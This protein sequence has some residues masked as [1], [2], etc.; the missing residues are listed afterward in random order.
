[1]ETK[2]ETTLHKVRMDNADEPRTPSRSR[3]HRV[4][5]RGNLQAE[6]GGLKLHFSYRSQHNF[7]DLSTT[8]DLNNS[9]SSEDSPRGIIV[10]V[11]RSTKSIAIRSDQQ[12]PKYIPMRDPTVVEVPRLLLNDRYPEEWE[13]AQ[14]ALVKCVKG[15]I[16][17]SNSDP[18]LRTKSKKKKSKL[19]KFL[20]GNL[21]RR[22]KKIL[23]REKHKVISKPFHPF[24]F[25]AD[26]HDR[27]DYQTNAVYVEVS[28]SL[29]LCKIYPYVIRLFFSLSS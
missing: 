28:E 23:E 6:D 24:T 16:A 13:S 22:K 17:S 3:L 15:E 11:K 5:C 7:R 18:C 25:R 12:F 29:E 26:M 8:L 14:R 10:N 20:R 4:S 21:S 2:S 19:K 1:M 27:F 9:S